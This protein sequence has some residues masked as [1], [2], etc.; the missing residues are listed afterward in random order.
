M[1]SLWRN[2]EFN[3]LWVGQCLSD[4]GDAVA[5]LALPL[6][7][8]ALTGSPVQAGLVGT[9]AQV[10]RL[11]C[12]LPAGVLVD[13]VN[14]RRAMLGCDLVRL[15]AFTVLGVAVVTGQANVVVII[16]I[17]VVDAAGGAVFGTAEH[18]ALRSIVPAPQLP[19]AV[20]RN[21]ARS[22]G[23][24]LAGPS[25][26][27][28]LFGLGHA[29][30]FFGNALSYL[31]SMI[32][33]ALIRRPLQTARQETT[34]GY[35]AA[36]AEGLRFVFRNPFLRAVLFISAPLNFAVTG[37]IFTIVVTLQRNGTPPAVIGLT[38]TILGVGGLL[39]AFAAPVLQRWLS[40]TALVRTICWTGA[41]LFASSA[42]LTA[43]IAAAIPVALALFLAPACNAALF[44]YQASITPDRL[45]GRVISVIFLVA[46]SAA[47]AAPILAGVFVTAWGSPTAI[48]IF[49][50]A[51][52]GSAIAATLGKGI[53]LYR[54]DRAA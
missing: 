3:L 41:G 35:A 45:Q 19:A 2:R 15:V 1:S 47:S 43:S 18:A 20:A 36:M 9:I 12:R 29:L 53:R 49:A 38:E 13:R 54:T 51:V 48:L 25:L 34:D 4:L 14:R 22:Y 30:P 21:E 23:T 39:G 40:L 6:L 44:G 7:V 27:G 24:S 42:L 50:L 10:I 46:S 32:G 16:A 11:V 33:V 26:G 52:A 31:A 28:L 17:A 8:L 37:I 5:M